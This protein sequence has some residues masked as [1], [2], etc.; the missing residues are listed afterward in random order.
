MKRVW[1]LV[2]CVAIAGCTKRQEPANPFRDTVTQVSLVGD[3]KRG[4][5]AG[6]IPTADLLRYG[7][8]G[9]GT[10]DSLDGEMMVL[11]GRVFRFAAD[12]Q[13]S[14]VA[15]TET[16]PSATVT[17]FEPDMMFDVGDMDDT[18]FRKTMDWK[19]PAGADIIAFRITGRFDVVR[20][21]SVPKQSLPFPPLDEVAK[22]TV[23]TEWHDTSGTMIGFY[24]PDA[25]KE[26]NWPGYHL[27]YIDDAREHGGHVLSFRLRQGRLEMDVC[28]AVQVLLGS[29]LTNGVMR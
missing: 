2:A 12:G 23:Q 29:S 28:T 22:S 5:Y 17:F 19:R 14:D 16:T 4:A 13:A 15:L 7:K 9:I 26:I 27:H 20:T 24:F 18:V 21:R 6:R 1:L 11:D 8:V 25:W 3:F 10:L